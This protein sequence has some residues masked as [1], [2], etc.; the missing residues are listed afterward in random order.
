MVP[1]GEAAKVSLLNT[2]YL[3]VRGGGGAFLGREMRVAI[4]SA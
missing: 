3:A 4:L 1:D 2:L